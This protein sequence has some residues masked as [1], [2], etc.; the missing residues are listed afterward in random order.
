MGVEIM[1]PRICIRVKGDRSKRQRIGSL[2]RGHHE[3]DA[4]WWFG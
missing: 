3:N 2:R 1:L 4:V